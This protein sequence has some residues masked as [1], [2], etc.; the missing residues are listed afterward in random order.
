MS[1][2]TLSH[3]SGL[4]NLPQRLNGDPE[5]LPVLRSQTDIRAALME[6]YIAALYFSFPSHLR[7]AQALP[8]LNGWLREMYEPLYDFFY[9][10]MK[11]EH[12]HHHASIGAGLDG[13]VILLDK[14]EKRKLDEASMGMS[15]LVMTKGASEGMQVLFEEK[16]FV[17]NIGLLYKITCSVDGI[18]LGEG[19]RSIKKVA[20]NAAAWEAAKKLGMLV[21]PLLSGHTT[22]NAD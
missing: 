19:T 5:L 6:A 14:E 1:N 4:Y 15:N 17:T 16:R 18:R 8:V 22:Y 3:L 7:I 21:D 9:H 20:K 13:Q 10:H 11:T 2:A 12:D